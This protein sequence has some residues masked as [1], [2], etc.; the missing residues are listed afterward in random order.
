MALTL[1]KPASE[2]TAPVYDPLCHGVDLPEETVLHPLG[3][4]MQLSTNSV[5]VIRAAEEQWAEFPPLFHDR[6]IEI[7]VAVSDDEQAPCSTGLIWR[8]QGHLLA[9]EADRYNFAVCDV[10]KGFSFCWLVPATAR[11][12][13][14]FR[15]HFLN[16]L[17]QAPLWQTHLTWVHAACVAR[18]GRAILLCGASGAGKTCLAY[19]CARRGWTLITDEVSSLVRGSQE[20]AVLGNPR[21]LHFRE[22]AATIMPELNGRLATPNSVGKFSIEVRAAELGIETAF[23]GR[24]AAIVFLERRPDLPARLTPVSS[25]DAFHGLECDLP[26]F[27]QPVYDAHLAALRHLVEGGAFELRYNHLDEAVSLLHSLVE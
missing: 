14:F 27:P 4:R 2:R 1:V 13:E 16:I 22:T 15:S 26:F 8:A 19:A 6:R 10:E 23:Q 21:Y 24:V 17:L 3:F 25:A 11:N 9:L 20:R 18:S 5:E 7:R 12:H